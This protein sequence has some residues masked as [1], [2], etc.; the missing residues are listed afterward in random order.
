MDASSELILF[1]HQC[2]PPTE[3]CTSS[4]PPSLLLCQRGKGFEEGN[5]FLR[6]VFLVIRNSILGLIHYTASSQRAVPQIDKRLS[7][8]ST[9]QSVTY[10]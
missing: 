9:L 3:S 1:L 10:F 8:A 7:R 6:A 2:I 4:Y 5:P